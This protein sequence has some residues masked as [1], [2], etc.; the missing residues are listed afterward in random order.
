MI[1]WPRP[2]EGL[3]KCLFTPSLG[4]CS[5]RRVRRS[6]ARFGSQTAAPIPPIGCSHWDIRW[7]F[8]PYSA[9]LPSWHPVEGCAD[10]GKWASCVGSAV[11]LESSGDCAAT[12]SSRPF[13]PAGEIH[14]IS[15]GFAVHLRQNCAAGAA[16]SAIEAFLAGSWPGGFLHRFAFSPVLSNSA[17][18]RKQGSWAQ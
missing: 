11:R 17:K 2:A 1:C 10:S 14:P 4:V 8:H 7:A 16:F 6:E 18:S 12:A 3:F 5:H 9:L 15:A 13:V